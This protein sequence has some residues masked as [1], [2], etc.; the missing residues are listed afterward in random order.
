MKY[1][2][3]LKIIVDV[4]KPP[5]CADN[6]GQEDCTEILKRVM[7]DIVS[8]DVWGVKYTWDKLKRMNPEGDAYL[9]FQSRR[10]NGMFNVSY[11]EDLHPTKIIWF[12]KGTYLVSDTISYIT[13]KSK[14]VNE[15]KYGYELNRGIH[16]EG[17]DRE[18]TVIMLEDNCKGFENGQI[19]P[20]ISF[21]QRSES[22][23]SDSANNAMLNTFEDLTID[24][25]SGNPGAIGLKFHAS[26]IGRISNVT[27]RSTDL[28]HKGFAGLFMTTAVAA[29]VDD[30]IIDGFDY[31]TLLMSASRELYENVEFKNQIR[32][33][34][35]CQ[36]S[37]CNIWNIKSDQSVPTFCADGNGV[38]AVSIIDDAG[39][40][41]IRDGYNFVYKRQNGKESCFRKVW[42]LSNAKTEKNSLCIPVEQTPK[43]EYPPVHEWVCVDDFGAAGDGCTDSTKAIQ[44]AFC[45]GAK[46]IYFNEG[47]YFIND[48]IIIPPDVEIINFAYCDFAAGE[49]LKSGKG[50]GAFVVS[51][52]SNKPLL[53]TKLFTWERFYGFFH[54]IRHSAKRDIILRDIHTQT[55]CVYFNTVP[56]SRV[57]L[58]NVACTTGDFSQWYLYRRPGEPVYSTNIP[59]EFHGQ[60]VYAK[61]LNPERADVEILND[62]S[63]LVLFGLY[64]EGPG[65][66]LKTINGG[67]SEVL[68]FTAGIGNNS[69]ET[70]LIINDKSAVSIVSG[71]VTGFDGHIYPVIVREITDDTTKQIRFEDLSVQNPY[72]AFLGGYIGEV[73]GRGEKRNGSL[74]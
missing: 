59:F 10:V 50:L 42:R 20:V 74:E 63:L 1:P 7:D 32:A 51:D 15:S 8:R 58:D 19:R 26:N 22:I 68:T 52:N 57:F 41:I 56:G 54:L 28:N 11:S 70:P 55:A 40:N 3:N 36:N 64:V 62:N 4:T 6:T 37:I 45:S 38:S 44:A 14:K 17:E 31:G 33:A 73:V 13:D 24:C 39:D 30:V 61:N 16:F 53:L 2:E 35:F 43:V 5:Y 72:R 46:I 47:R 60:K 25:G 49:K 12:P 18:E 9:G 34:I 65:T 21:I 67:R 29:A 69:E 27:I 66:A 71:R 23:V 48:E